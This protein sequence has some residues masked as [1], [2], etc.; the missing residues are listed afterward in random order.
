MASWPRE[1]SLTDSSQR[2]FLFP[3]SNTMEFL[4]LSGD[5]AV[6]GIAVHRRRAV[7]RDEMEKDE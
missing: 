5:V 2:A 7:D 4:A 3:L 6:P 1:G